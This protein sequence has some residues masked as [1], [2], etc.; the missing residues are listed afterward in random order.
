VPTKLACLF[1]FLFAILTSCAVYDALDSGPYECPMPPKVQDGTYHAGR[2]DR[3]FSV[4]EADF[5]AY[6]SPITVVVNRAAARVI[7]YYSN[8]TTLYTEEWRIE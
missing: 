5:D 1:V 8:E 7:I 4:E 3:W 6:P 2:Y